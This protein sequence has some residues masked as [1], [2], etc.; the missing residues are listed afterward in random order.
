MVNA[1]TLCYQIAGPT[2]DQGLST[3][4]SKT[5]PGDGVGGAGPGLHLRIFGLGKSS[6]LLLGEERGSG[7]RP[8]PAALAL[9]VLPPD[10]PGPWN[11][12]SLFSFCSLFA[13]LCP[14]LNLQASGGP[15]DSLGIQ[16]GKKEASRK[17]GLL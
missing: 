1:D 8:S 12:L 5:F 16:V 13:P 14:C 17:P 6:L 11:G 4:V 2:V 15:S 7:P 3:C 10:P 9:Q